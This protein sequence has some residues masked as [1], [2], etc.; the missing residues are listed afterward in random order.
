MQALR[1]HPFFA[2]LDWQTLWTDPAPPLE[3]GLVKRDSVPQSSN[4][5]IR[6]AWDDL[7]ENAV[8]DDDGDEGDDTVSWTSNGEGGEYALSPKPTNGFAHPAVIGPYGEK[9]AGTLPPI[10]LANVEE[11]MVS[12]SDGVRFIATSHSHSSIPDDELRDTVRDILDTP[13]VTR[14]QPIDVPRA[15]GPGS[16]STGSVTSSSDGSPV[17][18]LAAA[19]DEAAR[20][21]NRAQTPIQGNG[22]CDPE[23]YVASLTIFHV[24]HYAFYGDRL[25]GTFDRRTSLM[26][27]DEHIVFNTMVEL[28]GPK[29]R[30]SRLLAMA[31]APKKN[32]RPRELVL[33]TRR[34]ICVKHKPGRAAQIRTEMFV[35]LPSGKEKE[36]D[37]RSLVSSVEPKGER[38]FVIITVSLP[39]D[40]LIWARDR[41]VMLMVVLCSRS[42]RS[43]TATLQGADRLRRLGYE[44]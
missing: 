2:P 25:T 30:A 44:K 5:S 11:E 8:D 22:L 7:D 40:N 21:R 34:L 9:R 36:K 6:L 24:F 14:S 43:R 15:P 32:Q 1:D 38:E 10:P 23:L 27:P 39:A 42:R 31:V 12:P 20:G 3:V 28:G 35:K 4:V 18:K 37:L 19:I 17:E 29:R 33:T 13:V 16:H 41:D 26:L